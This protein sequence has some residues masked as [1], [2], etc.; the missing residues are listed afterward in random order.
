V[1]FTILP[2]D[3][4]TTG[5]EVRNKA[6]IVFDA[7]P[8]INTP[9]WLNTIDNT[10]PVSR[11]A[12]L[13]AQ[14][15]HSF[16]VNWSGSD[17]ASGLQDLTVFVSENGGQF[18]TWLINTSATSAIFYGK[19]STTYAFYSLA[20]DAVGN[21]E[22]AK[23]IAE[24]TTT[25]PPPFQLLLDESGPASNQAAALDSILFLRDPFAIV[26]GA[27]FFNLGVDRNTRVI[28]F[29][30]NLQLAQGETSSSVV[31]NLIDSNN[32]SYDI[33]AEDV[34]PVPNFNFTQVIFRLPDNL[35]VGTCTIKVKAHGQISN[36]GTIRIRI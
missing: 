35:P 15:S 21:H 7:N 12:P 36:A 34:R 2:K 32:Q 6:S 26:N 29:L 16:Q 30:T 27:D 19:A 10:N 20:R 8:P 28:I 24:A 4:L 23:T 9:E 3:V 17:I 22:S 31:V 13:S 14:S 18:T 11:V 33:A 25:T 1:L 5:T